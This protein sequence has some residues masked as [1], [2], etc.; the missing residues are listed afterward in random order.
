M[1]FM[2]IEES[3]GEA[4]VRVG[5]GWVRG[6]GPRVSDKDSSVGA[7]AVVCEGGL[8][9]GA[10]FRMTVIVRTVIWAIHFAKTKAAPA[11]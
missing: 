4:R 5:Y 7:Q 6:E 11:P 10:S 1:C 8:G 2:L 3:A 9:R